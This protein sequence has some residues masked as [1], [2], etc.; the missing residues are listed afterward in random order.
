MAGYN[1]RHM[2]QLSH[3]CNKVRDCFEHSASAGFLSFYCSAN[4]LAGIYNGYFL[5]N[6]NHVT[7]FE[8]IYEDEV[9]EDSADSDY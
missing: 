3:C 8:P 1:Q 7:T 2:D 4:L 6:R 5:D 9:V